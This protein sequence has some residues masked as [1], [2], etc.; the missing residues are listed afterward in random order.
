MCVTLSGRFVPNEGG[1]VGYVAELGANMPLSGACRL[2][3]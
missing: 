1:V 3:Q 2:G